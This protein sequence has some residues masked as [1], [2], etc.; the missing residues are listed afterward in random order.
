MIAGIGW[1]RVNEPYYYRPIIAQR[2]PTSDLV[3][4]S[5]RNKYWWVL[6]VVKLA[7][8]IGSISSTSYSNSAAL[9]R[10]LFRVFDKVWSMLGGRGQSYSQTNFNFH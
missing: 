5:V 8:L 1:A 4:R 10:G 9:M 7:T 3:G 2:R 6:M